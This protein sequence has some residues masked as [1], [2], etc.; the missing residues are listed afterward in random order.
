MD[1][2]T[3][4]KIWMQPVSI[5]DERPY[6][7]IYDEANNSE[8]LRVTWTGAIAAADW[9]QIP[10]WNDY[11]EGA[12]VAPSTG[13]SYSPLDI[14]AYYLI[15]FKL[16]AAPSIVRDVIYISHRVQQAGAT[17]TNE[18]APMT[19]RAGSSPARDDVE[20]LSFL[21]APATIDVTIGTMKYTYAA[22]AGV[23]AQD[24][25]LAGGT[26]SAVATRNAV[27]R[28]PITSPYAVTMGNV[29]HSKTKV[30]DSCRAAAETEKLA[31]P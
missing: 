31:D 28:G 4:G 25:P 26:V 10:T 17:V 19:L 20:V 18:T 2:H 8:N 24:Y 23:N 16:G 3:R 11:S 30:T 21:T 29:N 12:E 9:V 14:S 1:A 5:Q 22:P 27:C 7:S 15:Q 6:A 13:T